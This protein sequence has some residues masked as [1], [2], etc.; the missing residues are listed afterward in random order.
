MGLSKSRRQPDPAL[1]AQQWEL[2]QQKK[3][4][5]RREVEAGG[6]GE[7]TQKRGWAAVGLYEFERANIGPSRGMDLI[8]RR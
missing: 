6:G 5:V 2:E 8:A 7:P 4:A 1:Q 3:A